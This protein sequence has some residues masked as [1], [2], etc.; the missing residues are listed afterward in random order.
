[1]SLIEEKLSEQFYQWEERGRGWQLWDK[2]VSPEPAFRPFSGHFLAQQL[3]I[4]DGR[5]PTFLSSIVAKLSNKLAD[6]QDLEAI[7]QEAEEPEPQ[8]FI[9]EKLIELQ[10]ALPAT[11]NIP[12]EL[13]EQFLSNLSLCREPIAFELLGTHQSV[14]AQFAA[15]EDGAATVRRQ[16]QAYFPEAV[17]QKRAGELE[18][19]GRYAPSEAQTVPEIELEPHSM[20]SEGESEHLAIK[21]RIGAEAE[22]L[23]YT[24]TYEEHFPD[25][26]GRADVVLRR[27]ELA[28]VVQVSGGV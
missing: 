14:I 27:G 22:T 19:N 20:G 25:V 11:L 18:K 12:K 7:G 26:K 28:V 4:D 3:I 17:F 24:V 16:L 6:R 8:I 1:M 21:N 13:F 9:R 2:P 15:H 5:R 10:T 23:D